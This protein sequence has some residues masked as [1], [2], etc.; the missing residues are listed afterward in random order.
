MR[1]TIFSVLV[2]ITCFSLSSCVY[3]KVTVIRIKGD[4]VTAPFGSITPIEGQ[5][6]SGTVIRQVYWSDQKGATPPA[7]SD[8]SIADK[9]EN[10]GNADI[11]K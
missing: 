10:T 11:K 9:T 3:N 2:L 8:I 6:V 5:G 1:R 4:K 7:L